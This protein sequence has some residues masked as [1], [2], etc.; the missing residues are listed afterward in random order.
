MIT[1]LVTVPAAEPVLIADLKKHLN[2]DSSFTDDDSYIESLQKVA[3]RHVEVI[4]NRKLITQTW[5]F[6]LQGWPDKDFIVMPYGKLQSI[7]HVK[8]TDADDTVNTDFDEDDEFTVDTDSDPGRIVLKY[9]ESYPSAT[10]A[11]QNPIE[12]QFVLG[13]G[14]AGANVPDEIIL[15]IKLMVAELYNNREINL[16]GVNKTTLDAFNNLL[17]PYKLWY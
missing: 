9:G 2:I 14:V 12:I 4:T 6:F 16:L 7:T 17:A 8:Y 1:T 13:Y 5:K 10:L 3:R 11:N 15:A